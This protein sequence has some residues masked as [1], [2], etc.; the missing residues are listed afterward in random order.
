[1]LAPEWS[2][3]HITGDIITKAQ[4]VR[5]CLDPAVSFTSMDI[6]QL[7]IRSYGDAAIATGRTTATTSGDAAQTVR[8]RFTD[9]FVRRN[10]RWEIVASQ[11]TRIP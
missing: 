2:V 10:G 1:M 11:A 7:S 3:I 9:V 4:A 8:L 5:M 6:D